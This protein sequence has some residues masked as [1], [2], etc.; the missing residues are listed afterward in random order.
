MLK[1]LP[2]EKVY[3]KAMAEIRIRLR[4]SPE[5]PE[6]TVRKFA[7]DDDEG[8]T[9]EVVNELE[10]I[11]NKKYSEYISAVEQGLVEKDDLKIQAFKNMDATIQSWKKWKEDFDRR[12]EGL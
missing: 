12:T 5:Y 7:L 9:V 8:V 4:V 6:F 2:A 3:G 10:Q 1:V 11:N